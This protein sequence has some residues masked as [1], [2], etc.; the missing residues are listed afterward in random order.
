[1]YIVKTK[2]RQYWKFEKNVNKLEKYTL[3]SDINWENPIIELR[4]YMYMCVDECKKEPK[5]NDANE[6][7]HIWIFIRI[8]LKQHLYNRANDAKFKQEDK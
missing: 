2:E 7:V 6:N 4:C 5:K 1:M 8:Y 3:V